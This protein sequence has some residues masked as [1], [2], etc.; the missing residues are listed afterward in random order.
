MSVDLVLSLVKY[1]CMTTVTIH[2]AKTHLS[3]LIERTLAGE[4]IVVMRGHEPVVGLKRLHPP[5]N[6]RRLGGLPGL[7]TRMSKD[8][9]APLADFEEYSS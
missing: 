1:A 6:R 7:I 8:F 9:D 4:A 2:Q 3:R 5:K